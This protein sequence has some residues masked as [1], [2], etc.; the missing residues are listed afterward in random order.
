MLADVGAGPQ[1]DCSSTWHAPAG[2][3]HAVKACTYVL[4]LLAHV[5]GMCVSCVLCWARAEVAGGT[6]AQLVAVL[7]G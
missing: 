5:A 1:A 4:L 2:A 3:V 6:A 7:P